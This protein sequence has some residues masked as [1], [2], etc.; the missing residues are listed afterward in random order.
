MFTILKLCLNKDLPC[1]I[2]KHKCRILILY[3]SSDVNECVTGVPCQNGGSCSNTNGGY[4]C[5]CPPGWK[6]ENC[7]ISE[8]SFLALTKS[9]GRELLHH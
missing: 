3:E 8:L 4:L 6:G 7:S 2:L 9:E 5:T 1:S